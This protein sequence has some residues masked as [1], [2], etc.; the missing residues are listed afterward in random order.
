MEN[1]DLE[2]FVSASRASGKSDTQIKSELL[3]AG[4]PEGSVNQFLST[5]A[6]PS[7]P[8]AVA[9]APHTSANG[10][11]TAFEYVL[12]FISLS[13]SATG[14]AGL[15]H[16]LVDS[17][18]SVQT[19]ASNYSLSYYSSYLIPFY[20]SSIIVSFPIFAFLA[21]RLRALL[22]KHPEVRMTRVRKAAI[23]IALIWTFL[24]M[25]IRLVETVYSFVNGT[26]IAAN[27]LSHLLVTLLVSG[28]IFVYFAFEVRKD[29]S[30]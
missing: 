7:I 16:H 29:I 20:I 9:V 15:L 28:S 11:W 30:Q 24:A 12:M 10:T 8:H 5:P 23:Y 3:A 22:E 18:I 2:R 25:M 1:Q 6:T 19:D 14:V 21:L 13:F 26:D 4:W 27:V 17:Q